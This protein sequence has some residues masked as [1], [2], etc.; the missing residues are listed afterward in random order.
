VKD[1]QYVWRQF[2][3]I[4]IEGLCTMADEYGF[5]TL[6]KTFALRICCQS[7]CRF[8]SVKLCKIDAQLRWRT[9]ARVK[10]LNRQG[11]KSNVEVYVYP[12]HNVHGFRDLDFYRFGIDDVIYFKSD[13]SRHTT[14]M[15]MIL[16]QTI[17]M[18]DR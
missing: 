10:F 14:W 7:S 5:V 3:D 17:D 9:F 13:P 6:D 18:Y 4:L 8:L 11:Q 12:K 16:N 1:V 2:Y 15:T